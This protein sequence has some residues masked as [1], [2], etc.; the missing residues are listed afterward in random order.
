M[1]WAAAICL[2]VHFSFQF[3]TKPPDSNQKEMWPNYSIICPQY[4]AMRLVGEFRSKIAIFQGPRLSRAIVWG[5]RTPCRWK[6]IKWPGARYIL[7]GVGAKSF[8]SFLALILHRFDGCF[9]QSG[10][11]WPGLQDCQGPTPRF[12]NFSYIY[13]FGAK[14]SSPSN[15]L[16]HEQVHS[17]VG[18]FTFA[19]VPLIS[20][21]QSS[22][23]VVWR[24]LARTRTQRHSVLL[25]RLHIHPLLYSHRIHP[26][27]PLWLAAL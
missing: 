19:Q 20:P 14:T 9:R 16:S 10:P 25:S 2:C 6:K 23:R 15:R 4:I 3:P 26:S 11:L 27:R 1:A 5:T 18:L 24:C 13:Y 17:L 8:S 7:Y 12:A 21:L 22:R